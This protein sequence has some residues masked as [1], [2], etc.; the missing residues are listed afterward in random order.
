MKGSITIKA[1]QQ[2]NGLCTSTEVDLKDVS[3]LDKACLL[4]AFLKG[5]EIEPV[6]AE[7]LLLLIRRGV[8]SSEEVGNG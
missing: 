6:E 3:K 1:E 5:L 8:V 4:N 7:I 2:G